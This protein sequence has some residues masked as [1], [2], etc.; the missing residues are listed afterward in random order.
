[1]KFRTGFV[2][3]SSS[4]CFMVSLLSNPKYKNSKELLDAILDFF[5][6]KAYPSPLVNKEPESFFEKWDDK[7][8]TYVICNKNDKDAYEN[9]ECNYAIFQTNYMGKESTANILMKSHCC[10]ANTIICGGDDLC[11][12]FTCD[13]DYWSNMFRP[14]HWKDSDTYLT[15]HNWKI[16]KHSFINF[17]S[18]MIK[19]YTALFI[20][21]YNHSP[22]NKELN[23]FYKN[24]D[25]IDNGLPTDPMIDTQ[26][27]FKESDRDIDKA[28]KVY[29]CL[30]KFGLRND[31]TKGY[32]ICKTCKKLGY[33]KTECRFDKGITALE[34]A[35]NS[36][37]VVAT[38]ENYL[39]YDTM[40][41]F[42]KEFNTNL[43]SEHI[44]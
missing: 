32:Y 2:T 28:L 41:E 40:Q 26:K 8:N 23:I 9:Y 34:M 19:I 37:I 18:N 42:E 15:P 12:D 36:D 29:K 43:F 30:P 17:K 38:G 21:C 5:I 7:L 22:S 24:M 33:C 1:M 6:R 25:N 16:M 35:M 27:V 44:G 39:G 3:N 4:S 10:S 13:Y 14:K 11:S 31:Y 20:E